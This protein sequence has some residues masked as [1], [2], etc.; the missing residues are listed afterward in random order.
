ML[1]DSLMQQTRREMTYKIKLDDN[2][3]VQLDARMDAAVQRG[4]KQM[5]LYVKEAFV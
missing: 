4:M 3:A 5:A 2:L 1:L